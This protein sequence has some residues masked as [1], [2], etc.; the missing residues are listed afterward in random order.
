MISVLPFSQE[1][2][3]TLAAIPG[4]V[5]ATLRFVYTFGVGQFGGRN[6]TVFTT[7][8]LAVPAIGI[9]VAVQNPDTP[10]STMLLL[11]ALCGLG[12]GSFFLLLLQILA[13]SSQKKKKKAQHLVLM[14]V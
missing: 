7:A 8:I 11:A 4:L 1:Q 9:G 13:S 10:Y 6:W 12:G 2:L 3:F 14:A 5:G